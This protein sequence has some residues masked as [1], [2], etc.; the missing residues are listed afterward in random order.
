MS[1]SCRRN[2]YSRRLCREI[3]NSGPAHHGT[4]TRDLWYDRPTLYP[5]TTVFHTCF[6]S[7]VIN[8]Y[9]YIYIT[10][11]YRN[12]QLRQI[13]ISYREIIP[14]VFS[15]LHIW[16]KMTS[17]VTSYQRQKKK[18]SSNA[19]IKTYFFFFLWHKF[20]SIVSVMYCIF[21]SDRFIREF[22]FLVILLAYDKPF[23]FLTPR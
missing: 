14:I 12:I 6:L 20:S 23:S 5:C 16:Y 18:L 10:T 7:C 21:E 17:Y 8:I 19:S 22:L 9:I 4:R 13:L 11:V 3:P 1:A 2:R 15:Q